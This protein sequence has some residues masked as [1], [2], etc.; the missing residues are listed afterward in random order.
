MSNRQPTSVYRP[1]S[2]WLRSGF[3]SLLEK[4]AALVFSFGLTVLLLRHLTK[5]DFAAWGVF[6]ILTY[7]VEMGRSGL[8]QNALM[9]QLAV[10]R[11][12]REACASISTAS[13]FL[14]F[15]FSVFSNLL[16]WL[17]ASWI[18]QQYHVPQIAQLLPLYF[19]VN[20]V[21]AFYTHGYFVQQ[22]N[23]EFRGVFWGAV[24]FRG[25]PFCW[26]LFCLLTSQFVELSHLVWAMLAGAVA[27]GIAVWLFARPFLFFSKK[28]DFQWVAK[29]FSFGKYVLGTNLSTMFYKNIDKL[30]LGHLLGPAAF[31]VYDAAGKVAQ[32]VEMPSFSVAAVVFP[33]S[34]ERMERDGTAGVKRL[35]ERSVAATLAII[36][37]FIVLV[38]LF[39]EPIIWL[40]AGEQYMASADVLRLTAF[41]GLFLPFAVQFGTVLDSTGKPATNFV[42]TTFT[43]LLNLG[44][45]YWFVMEFGLFGAAFATLLGY[46]VSF[47]LMQIYLFKNFRINVLSVFRYVPEVYGI[48]WDLIKRKL[49]ASLNLETLKP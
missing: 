29:L 9:R 25:L 19:V 23:S 37:P 46:A 7:F 24:F 2:H 4:G 30:T 36:L 6:I 18:S 44:L 21:M 17:G 35:Y 42:Y 1:P 27:G 15:S 11:H 16:L 40:L 26:V 34:A 39:A 45:S 20:F 8:I 5:E 47:G 14:N 28:I 33:H 43:A 3:F 32:L 22:A 31:A 48:G 13:F 38:L 41:F 12:D 49:A 10:H